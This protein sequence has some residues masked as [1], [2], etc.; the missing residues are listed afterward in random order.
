MKDLQ[1]YF[2]LL[3]G[4]PAHDLCDSV[5]KDDWSVSIFVSN[6]S[7]SSFGLTIL[8]SFAHIEPVRRS[9]NEFTDEKNNHC[10]NTV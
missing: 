1:S 2:Y 8:A 4:I 6:S 7:D 9:R 10:L 3:E 5:W